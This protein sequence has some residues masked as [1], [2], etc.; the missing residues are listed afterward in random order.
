[1][2]L[3]AFQDGT[4][5]RVEANAKTPASL[6]TSKESRICTRQRLA[7]ALHLA[8]PSNLQDTQEKPESLWKRMKVQRKLV[9]DFAEN[10]TRAATAPVLCSHAPTRSYPQRTHY[11]PAKTPLSAV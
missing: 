5:S 8:M 6:V 3:A 4:V 2:S 7:C 1:M 10:A 9:H 11:P